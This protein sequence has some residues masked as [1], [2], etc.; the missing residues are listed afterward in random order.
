MSIIHNGEV[1]PATQDILLDKWK[2]DFVEGITKPSKP[3]ICIFNNTAYALDLLHEHI[4]RNSTMIM[5]TDVD[6][7]GVGTTYILKRSLERFGSN[8][9]ILMINKDK[10]HG[11]QK[12]HAD[13]V[14]MHKIADLVIITDSS[15]N[16]IE[17]I[18]KF[19]CDVLV[20]D[21]HDLLHE[22]LIGYCND[23]KHRYVIVNNNIENKNQ[24][25]DNLWLRKMNSKAFENI[26]DYIV[27]HNMS[28]GLVVYELLRVYCICFYEEK[29]L[30]N[31][32]LFQWA[33]ITL[34]TDVIDTLNERNQWYLDQTVFN[35]DTEYSLRIMMNLIN[36]YKAS[37]DKTYIQYTFAPLINKAIRAGASSEVVTKVVNQPETIEELKKYGDLQTKAL[38]TALY[39]TSKDKNTGLTTKSAR[40]FNSEHIAFNTSKIDV[41]A[42]YSGV[43][44]SRLSGDNGKNAA[45]FKETEEG[46][47][48]GSFRGRFKTVDY[49]KYFENFEQGIYA[50]GHP[51]AFG[52][53]LTPDQMN[54]IMNNLNSIEPKEKEKPFLTAGNMTENEYGTYHIKDL[55]EFKRQGYVWRIATGNA[56]VASTDEICIRVKSCDVSLKSATEKVFIYDVLG[57]ECKAFKPLSGEYFDIYMELAAEVN[58]Y[59][60]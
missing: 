24:E 43:I 58:M 21:H 26:P 55:L 5:H 22:D 1:I 3:D 44:A 19:E 50:Q 57:F 15:C 56:K 49:R 14:N 35:K 23:G 60:K 33:G 34:F 2:Y 53:E 9:H 28:C 13:Y 10:V 40:V 8:K 42:N 52:F 51:A 6:V 41:H 39:V 30:E 25:M 7:D 12:K 38:E 11:V 4:K 37:L 18:K 27:E 16:E 59:I 32:L 47:Y 17:T 54:N 29:L 31:L 36:K 45:V 48:K 20:I 46:K